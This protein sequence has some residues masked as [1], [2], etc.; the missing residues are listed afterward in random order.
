MDYLQCLFSFLLLVTLSWCI[1]VPPNLWGSNLA[2]VSPIQHEGL[3]RI[4]DLVHQWIR[5]MDWGVQEMH[6]IRLSSTVSIDYPYICHGLS[7]DYPF[8]LLFFIR[9]CLRLCWVSRFPHFLIAQP[10]LSQKD[11]HQDESA[12]CFGRSQGAAARRK[13]S[14]D[15]GRGP[16]CPRDGLQSHQR[17]GWA[18]VASLISLSRG[19]PPP[20]RVCVAYR[21]TNIVICNMYMYT[22]MYIGIRICLHK[23]YL[24]LSSIRSILLSHVYLCTYNL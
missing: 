14:R 4:D 7:I 8:T 17:P 20:T 19:K 1:L 5:I 6:H 18:E 12:A 23:N 15:F 11:L 10:T 22:Y 16:C 21:H 13:T 9:I 24:S 2:P 3:R